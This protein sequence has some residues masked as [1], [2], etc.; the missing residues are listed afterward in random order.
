MSRKDHWEG[1]YGTKDP[2]AVSWY[3]PRLDLSLQLLEQ[4][5]LP[6]DA[7][8]LDVGGGASTFVDDLLELGYREITVVDLSER[9]MESARERLGRAAAGVTWRVGDIT[10]L[11]LPAERY[12][13]WHDRAVF[14]FLVEASERRRYVQQA[15]HALRPSGRI[16]VAT[17][18]PTGPE[19]CSGLPVARYDG[20]GVHRELGARFEALGSFQEPHVTPWGSEQDFVYSYCRRA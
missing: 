6:R 2:E 18:G 16:V 10:E 14:H 5:A 8:I 15:L 13:F 7:P 3:R 9:A 4:A 12:A 20:E 19:E 17:F 1:V 11:E